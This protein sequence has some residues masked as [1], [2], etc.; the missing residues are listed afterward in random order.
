MV[1]GIFLITHQRVRCQHKENE[2]EP[3]HPALPA[4]ASCPACLFL[5]TAYRALCLRLPKDPDCLPCVLVP[6]AQ[7]VL[8]LVATPFALD[9]SALATNASN[10]TALDTTGFT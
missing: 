2:A 6:L 3:P 5:R 1:F 8:D 9:A 7:V 10:A 4:V